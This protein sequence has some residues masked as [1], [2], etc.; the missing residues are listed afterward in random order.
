MTNI[1][2]FLGGLAP[3]HLPVLAHSCT[4]PNIKAPQ[5]KQ[6]SPKRP[7]TDWPGSWAG[8]PDLATTA[9]PCLGLGFLQGLYLLPLLGFCFLQ[10]LTR[11]VLLTAAQFLLCLSFSIQIPGRI[12]AHC[13]G[14]WGSGSDLP[15][16]FRPLLPHPWLLDPAR[17]PT[18]RLLC[19]LSIKR[20]P[21]TEESVAHVRY[22]HLGK[23]P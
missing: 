9:K 8:Q 6:N 20:N 11:F 14:H 16:R 10:S 13:L 4:M 19:A 18:T 1:S 21:S 5:S 12:S 17:S 3:S 23:T 22:S 7:E 2:Q 15:A